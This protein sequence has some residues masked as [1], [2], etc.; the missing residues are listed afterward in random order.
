MNSTEQRTNTFAIVSLV[1]G[2]LGMSVLAIVFG[3][4]AR[5]Q[6]RRTGENGNGLALAGL[7][8]GYV[9]LVV[10]IAFFTFFT[11]LGIYRAS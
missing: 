1:T 7:I 11:G 3:H 9:A 2:V 10:L 5:S 4:I 6:I 8:L